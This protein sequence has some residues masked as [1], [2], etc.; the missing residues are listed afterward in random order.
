MG[1]T[2]LDLH[3]HEGAE[4][5]PHAFFAEMEGESNLDRIQVPVKD[6][7]LIERFVNHF[8][9]HRRDRSGLSVVIPYPHPE[10]SLDLMIG[11]AI[12]NYF[13]PVITEQL[14]VEFGDVRIDSESI[15]ELAHEYASN[16]FSD[17]DTLFDFIEA[18]HRQQEDELLIV[19]DSWA[20]NQTLDEDDFDPGTLARIIEQFRSGNMISLKL[21]IT[22]THKDGSRVSTWFALYLQRPE[23]LAKGIDL[24]VRGGLTLPGESKFRERRALGALIAEEP[25]ICGFLGDAEN[26]AHTRWIHAAEKVKA[27]YRNPQKALTVIK[28]ALINLYDMLS[29]DVEEIDE[30]A[31]MDFF[32][33]DEVSPRSNKKPRKSP[34]TPLSLPE[35]RPRDFGITSIEG[36]FVV[37]NTNKASTEHLPQII[38]VSMAYDV[39]GGNPFKKYSPLDF[40]VDRE[41]IRTGIIRE[42]GNLIRRKDNVI[43]VEVVDLPFR[44]RV[45]GFDDARDLKVKLSTRDLKEEEIEEVGDADLEDA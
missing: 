36:G 40:Q 3:Q 19:R 34:P 21:P 33:A 28:N 29:D 45:T 18:A 24:Y 4:Y 42:S 26:P 9:L 32:W 10:L 43:V 22:L 17:I 20:N 15:R 38:E 2:V 6:K 35:A 25:V 8:D 31:L 37:A 5:P 44:L 23:R 1:Q 7:N 30:T 16:E 39:A 12:A 14:V 27:N 41:G 11:L 13:F